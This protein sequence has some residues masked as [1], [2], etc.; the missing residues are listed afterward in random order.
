MI[1]NFIVSRTITTHKKMNILTLLKMTTLNFLLHPQLVLCSDSPTSFFETFPTFL[2]KLFLT[3]N[4][5]FPRN[6]VSRVEDY[7]P[8]LFSSEPEGHGM[9]RLAGSQL[10][11]WLGDFAATSGRNGGFGLIFFIATHR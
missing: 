9:L 3:V 2:R 7:A 1:P 10:T 11:F 6:E 4:T 5:H 8:R